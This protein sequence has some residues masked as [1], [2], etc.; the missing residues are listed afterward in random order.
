M[1]TSP[2]M[3]RVNAHLIR[4]VTEEM[5]ESE[6]PCDD[7]HGSGTR[8]SARLAGKFPILVDE[9][10]GE[11]RLQDPRPRWTREEDAR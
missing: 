2:S 10:R 3:R 6:A 1:S 7:P 8:G 4:T 5:I 11:I 9:F